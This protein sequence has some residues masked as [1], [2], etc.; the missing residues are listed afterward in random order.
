MK[1][2]PSQLNVYKEC[3]Q[4]WE[5]VYIDGYKSKASKSYFDVGNYAHE[6]MHVYY[7]MLRSGTRAGSDFAFAAIK[8][9][10]AND[11]ANASLANV[12]TYN[13]VTKTMENFISY[14]SPKIDRG[15]KIDSVEGTYEL[16]VI[17]PQGRTIIFHGIID[18]TYR[19]IRRRIIVRDHKTSGNAGAWNQRKVDLDPQIMM[20]CAVVWKL[21]GEVPVGEIN[22]LNTHQYKKAKPL[23]ELFELYRVE[24]NATSLKKFWESTLQL[25]DLMLDSPV[26]PHYSKDCA[27]CQFHDVCKLELRGVSAKQILANNFEVV[28]RDY[29]IVRKSDLSTDHTRT[30]S[31]LIFDLTKVK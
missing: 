7:Q 5:F 2:S 6:L 22:F 23:D 8:S 4:K 1:F 11:L 13:S 30:D 31:N 16:E 24:H 3:P 28:E 19:D 20:Y 15:I 10:I 18:L 12:V 29:S 17:T 21:T 26:V 9:R 14:Q 25:I 27:S